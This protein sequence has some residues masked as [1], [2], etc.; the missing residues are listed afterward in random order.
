MQKYLIQVSTFPIF[1]QC[2]NN[3]YIV[4]YHYMALTQ[5]IL[6]KSN[7]SKMLETN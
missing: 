6:Q 7:N 3:I 2:K 5:L 4:R 1:S